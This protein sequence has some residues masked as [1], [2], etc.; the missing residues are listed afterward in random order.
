[1]DIKSL[2]NDT[3]YILRETFATFKKPAIL[4]SMGKDSSCAVWLARKAFLGD[5]PFP[6]I[7]LDTGLKY[8]EM[9][10]FREKWATEWNLDLRVAKSKDYGKVGPKDGKLDCCTKLKTNAL[11]DY[12]AE[13]GFD[14]LILAI[15]RDEHS[16]RSKERVYS[17]RNKEMAWQFRSQPLEVWDTHINNLKDGEHMRVHPILG[18]RELDVWEYIRQEGIPVNELYF[19]KNKKRFRS[20]GCMPCTEP[21]ESDADTIDKIVEELKTT[22]VAEREGRAQDKENLYNMQSLR[23][24]GY[25]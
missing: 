10:N 18:W 13:Q 16:I 20:L 25:M 19:A 9:Y 2:E 1:M 24:L 4:W 17:P 15:R 3:I 6:V 22:K 5:I 21:I 23:S 12:V 11:K 14:A 7:H 8:N